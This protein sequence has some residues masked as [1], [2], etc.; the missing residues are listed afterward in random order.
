M[1]QE[2]ARDRSVSSI[3][4]VLEKAGF[5]VTDTHSVRPTSFDLMARR[6]STL[7]ILKVL[8]NM[9]ALDAPEA[10]RLRELAKLFGAE[11]L[12]IGQSSGATDLESGVVYY[13]Y[14]APIITEASLEEYLL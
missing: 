9:D 4:A 6:D 5:F 8:K 1:T 2:G 3:Q 14:G 11:V 12:V 13:R 7:V 10:D